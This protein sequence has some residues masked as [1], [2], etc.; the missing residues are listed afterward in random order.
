VNENT[1]EEN[2]LKKSNQKCILDDLVIQN[3][4]YNIEFFKNLYPMEL[5]SRLKGV[6]LDGIDGKSQG[7]TLITT[8]IPIPSIG[9][10]KQRKISIVEVE[11]T[12]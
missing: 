9:R 11:I 4:N 2:I 7:T 6:K 1:I 8:N 5:F 3:G 12:L 10:F